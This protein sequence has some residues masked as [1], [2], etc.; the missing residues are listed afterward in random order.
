MNNLEL[1]ENIGEWNFLE[2]MAEEAIRKAHLIEQELNEAKARWQ[3]TDQRMSE[4]GILPAESIEER[5][6]NLL[7]RLT[8]TQDKNTQS[9]ANEAYYDELY[10][11]DGL[12]DSYFGDD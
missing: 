10:N 4:L 7:H 9:Q 3:E 8:R 2:A 1:S 5:S 12:P 6:S 11:D